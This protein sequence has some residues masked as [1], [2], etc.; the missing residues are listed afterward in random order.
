M[1]ADPTQ[2]GSQQGQDQTLFGTDTEAV[3]FDPGYVVVE[4]PIGVGK[5]SLARRLAQTFGY[6]TVLEEPENNPFLEGFYRSPERYALAVQ[7]HFLYERTAEIAAL[8]DDGQRLRCVSDFLIDKD[9]LFAK[10]NLDPDE[11]E[12]YMRV[13]R[14][15]AVEAPAPDLVIYLQAPPQVLEERIR[16]RGNSFENTMPAGYLQGVCDAYASHFLHYTD[17]PLLVINAESINFVDNDRDFLALVEH[18]S[19]IRSG[20]HFFNPLPAS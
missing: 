17:A 14:Q 20:R 13:Y 18:A 2:P 1:A 15:V 12:L 6:A 11:F 9:P 5:T 7:L 3:N 10:L 19:T 16:R 8:G 4:G